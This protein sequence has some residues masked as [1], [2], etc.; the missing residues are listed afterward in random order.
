MSLKIKRNELLAKYSSFKIGGPAKFFAVVKT[1]KDLEKIFSLIKKRDLPFFVFGGG[2]NLLFSDKGY[3]GVVIKIQNQTFKIFEEKLEGRKNQK[4]NSRFKIRCGAGLL[5]SQLIMKSIEA[6]FSGLEW[7]IGIPGTI[8]GAVASNCGAYGHSIAEFVVSILTID[9][10]GEVKKY[11]NKNCSF[12]YRTSR[13]KKSSNQEIIWEIELKLKKGN[14]KE[15]EKIIKEIL[16]KRQG[17]FPFFPSAGSVFKN[18]IVDQIKNKTQI[19]K[20]I[21][22]DKIKGGKIPVGYLIEQSEL[23]GKKIGDA[24][25]SEKHANF[26]INL[27]KAKAKDV[28]KLI[29]FAKKKV[30]EKFGLDLEEEIIIVPRGGIEP[31]TQCSS[32]IRST[33]ELPRRY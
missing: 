15:S 27:G 17:K 7:G 25:I 16:A 6:G 19:L 21:P 33:T 32:G 14:K 5:L 29:N 11:S 3:N 31:P 8:G 24:Q 20:L 10:N 1:K 4:D 23:K 22:P 12:D 30:K 26:I 13:F 28:K 9:K 18:I 2:T